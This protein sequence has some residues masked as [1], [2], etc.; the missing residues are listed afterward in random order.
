MPGSSVH[1]DSPGRNMREGCHALPVGIFPTQGLNPGLPH[2]RRI[3]YRLSHQGNNLTHFQ[4]MQKHKKTES[5]CPLEKASVRHMEWVQLSITV[6]AH[7]LLCSRGQ[8]W[9]D[10]W[11]VMLDRETSLMGSDK[12]I[13]S[14]RKERTAAFPIKTFGGLINLIELKMILWFINVLKC[15]HEGEWWT[16]FLHGTKKRK[17]A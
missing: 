14:D 16:G 15:T 10:I 7:R 5:G 2:C 8:T 17:K 6:K 11:T 13:S 4:I 1:G 3:L 12:I 9:T